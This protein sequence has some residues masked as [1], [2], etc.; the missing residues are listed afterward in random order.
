GP[1]RRGAV[2]VRLTHDAGH[3]GL[4][5]PAALGGHGARQR[6]AVGSARHDGDTQP[7]SATGRRGIRHLQHPPHRGV[8]DRFGSDRRVHAVAHRGEPPR[9]WGIDRGLRGR[10]AAGRH[11]VAL[12]RR[13]G[14]DDAAA[15]GGDDRGHRHRG[16]HGAAEAP[17]DEG[18]TRSLD[19]MPES[20]SVALGRVLVVGAGRMGTALTAALRTAGVGVEGPAGRGADGA[21][22]DIVLLAVPDAAIAA[23]AASLLP[24]RLVGHLSG[25]TTLEPLAPHEAF[26]L[27]PLMTVPA[28]GAV[29][30]GVPAAVAG[31]TE[32]ARQ[33]AQALATALGMDAFA[34][35]DADRTAYHA[36][37]SVASNY[38]VALESVAEDLAAT[39]GVDRDALVP[40]VR[41]AVENWADHGAAEALTGPV[42]RGDEETVA[43]QRAAVAE[44][45]PERLA[46]FDALTDVARALR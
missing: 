11:R 24:G 38:L 45:M 21:D 37:A 12:L 19:S 31:S 39:A 41:A 6:G 46:L 17:R 7:P 18:L 22:A 25:A 32:R 9:R 4:D 27:H 28:S 13:D 10:T 2:L 29:F 1:L 16:L 5:V 33:V 14:A 36:A 43:R 8:G 44:R 3:P 34:V 35:R 26:S 15:G 40:L 30:A 23:A 42:A 20:P